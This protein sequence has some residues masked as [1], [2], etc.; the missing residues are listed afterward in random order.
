MGLR[1]V[2]LIPVALRVSVSKCGGGTQEGS[3]LPR[4]A[5]SALQALPAHNCLGECADSNHSVVLV[6]ACVTKFHTIKLT[7]HGF[8]HY[9]F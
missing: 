1:T 4:A 6:L 9:L 3:I 8:H 5:P 2:H 7:A